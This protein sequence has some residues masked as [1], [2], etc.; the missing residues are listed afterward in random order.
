MQALVNQREIAEINLNAI[1]AIHSSRN[2][3]FIPHAML[4]VASGGTSMI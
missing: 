2:T 1:T 4:S 3:P